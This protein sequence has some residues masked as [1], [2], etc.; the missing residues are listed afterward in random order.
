MKPKPKIT[1]IHLLVT[2][3]NGNTHQAVLTERQL[4]AIDAVLAMGKVSLIKEPV[5]LTTEKPAKEEK[6]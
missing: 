6:K 2:L 4:N 3:D 5:I 1:N